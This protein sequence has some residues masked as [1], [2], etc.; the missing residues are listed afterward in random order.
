MDKA[1]ACASGDL[2]SPGGSCRWA[3]Q[4]QQS[5]SF[6]ATG[7]SWQVDLQALEVGKWICGCGVCVSVCFSAVC[8]CGAENLA[9]LCSGDFHSLPSCVCSC[10]M[11]PINSKM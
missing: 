6:P 2:Q 9:I 8:V 5:P 11:T 3:S 10:A 1:E 4:N 7:S